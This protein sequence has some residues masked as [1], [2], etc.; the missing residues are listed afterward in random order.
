MRV[1]VMKVLQDGLLVSQFLF[2]CFLYFV[3]HREH[4]HYRL[5]TQDHAENLK[6]WAAQSFSNAFIPSIT[7]RKLC[8]DL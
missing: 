3:S 4:F 5:Y 8:Q 6:E 1:C 7:S 2:V